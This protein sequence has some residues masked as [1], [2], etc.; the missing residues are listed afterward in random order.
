MGGEKGNHKSHDKTL[1]QSF[2][3]QIV[4][5][6]KMKLVK[7]VCNM[8][9]KSVMTE[10][11]KNADSTCVFWH[12]QPEIPEVLLKKKKISIKKSSKYKNQVI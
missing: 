2:K 8:M 4:R 11:Y 5:R 7:N 9:F 1:I 12:Y 3:N 10:A 6:K